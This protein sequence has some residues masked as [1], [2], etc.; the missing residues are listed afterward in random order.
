MMILGE[1]MDLKRSG[2]KSIA[3]FGGGVRTFFFRFGT[4]AK[5]EIRKPQ[6]WVPP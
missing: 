1:E 3:G 2:G 5:W 4:L 6:S